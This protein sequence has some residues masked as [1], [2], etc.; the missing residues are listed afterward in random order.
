MSARVCNVVGCGVLIP[1]DARGGRCPVH[2]AIVRKA[3]GDR[4]NRYADAQLRARLLPAAIN[5]PCPRCHRLMTADQ[6]LDLGHTV[7]YALDPTSRPDR[8]EHSLCN[9]S[10]GGKL[11]HELG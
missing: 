2:R 5:T 8:I 3:R 11:G 9:R 4:P 1:A 6:Q 7:S 10:A